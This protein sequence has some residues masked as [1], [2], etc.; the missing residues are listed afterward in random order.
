MKTFIN[1]TNHPSA[2]WSDEQ[3]RAAS[4]YGIVVDYT[5]PSV[6][7]YANEIEINDLAEE[8]LQ[9]I[10]DFSQEMEVTAIHAMG[11]QSFMFAFVKKAQAHGF[12]CV[13]STTVRQPSNHFT[14]YQFRDYITD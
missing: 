11:E 6:S 3:K 9:K 1:M 10:I 2:K 12:R 5:P 14:F 8:Y 7:P 4:E 13:V